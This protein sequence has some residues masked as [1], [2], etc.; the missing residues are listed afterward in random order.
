VGDTALLGGSLVRIIVAEIIYETVKG[1]V[2]MRYDP[3]KPNYENHI[4]A[5]EVAKTITG[6]PR[7]SCV[8]KTDAMSIW[9]TLEG[10]PPEHEIDTLP[11]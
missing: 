3:D 2:S 11:F 5:V 7:F 4:D 1:R 10:D 9:R 8:W 6:V